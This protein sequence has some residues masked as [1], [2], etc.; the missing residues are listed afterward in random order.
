MK[1]IKFYISTL[2][3]I[4]IASAVLYS[5]CTTDFLKPDPLSFYE[6]ETTFSTRS[7]LDA[8]LAL[9]DRHLRTY[10]GGTTTRDAWVPISTEYMLSD[11]AVS[12]KTDAGNIFA[13]VATRLTPTDGAYDNNVNSIAYFW[14][15]T[16]AGIKHANAITSFIDNVPDLDETTK[17]EYLG[18]AYFHRSFRYLA[19]CFQYND[20]PLVTKILRFPKRNFKT[21]SREAI[22]EMIT[23]DM[24]KAV[25]WVPDQS[26]M[27]LIGLV[28]KGACRQLL[29]KCYLATGQWDKAIEQ[30]NILIN[31]SGYALMTDHFGTFDNPNPI[32]WP[33]TRNVIWD[34][35][36]PVNKAIAANTEAIL[37]MPNREATDAT[38]QYKSMR[39]WGPMWNQ[40]TALKSPDGK[41]LLAVGKTDP[42]Y[43]AEYDINGAIGR[44]IATIRP[45]HFAQHGLWYVNGVDDETDLRHNSATGNWAR[46]EML[47]YNDPTDAYFGE[48][49]RLEHNGTLLCTD[50][51][52]SWFNWPHYKIYIDDPVFLATP[53]S[54]RNDGGAADWY[55]Y[56]LA[57]TYLLRA[58]AHF[59]KGN[60]A[61]ATADVNVVRERAQC[62]QLYTTVNIG[63][64]VNERARELYMEEWRHM[65]LSR[66]SYSLALSGKPDEFGNTYDENTLSENSYWYQRIQHYNDYYNKDK[67]TVR[68]RKYTMAPHNIYWPIPQ[69][70]INANI[71]GKLSQNP[72]YDGYDPSVE[73]WTN[74]QDAVADEDSSGE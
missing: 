37:V 69:N 25:E 24:E 70:A 51:I 5:G 16:Y 12:G 32:S 17:Q 57:E 6:P 11:I 56:R 7:G 63:D 53:N 9:A 54:N 3:A 31:Q 39:N 66:I 35:H 45:T 40:G 23:A 47:K 52:R 67:V 21:T 62:S 2:S 19:L 33:I 43:R 8:T 15:Q 74:W 49:L 46:M 22:L 28:N 26:Q 64:I 68:N 60:I 72:G 71:L 42:K 10:W 38:I 55:F 65:E 27:D 13:D 14:G 44:G 36:R 73:M 58:E 61:E 48:N 20:V 30:A 34:L 29:I 41:S 59:Y 18:R 4:S 50:T 1:K